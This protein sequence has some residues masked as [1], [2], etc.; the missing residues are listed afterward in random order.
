[1][2]TILHLLKMLT[3]IG[4]VIQPFGILYDKSTILKKTLPISIA[5]H[6]YFIHYIQYT[7]YILLYIY[8][9]LPVVLIT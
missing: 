8:Y 9:V 6:L 1:M 7:S 5:A 3:A 2:G 4:H